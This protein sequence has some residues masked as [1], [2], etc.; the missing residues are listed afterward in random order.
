VK[1]KDDLDACVAVLEPEDVRA[2]F[3]AAF[4]RF[5]PSLD[6]MLPDPKALPYVGH[7]RW[8]GKIRQV[9]AAKYRD[10]KIDISD[11][12]AKVRKLIEESI[13]AACIQKSRP[14]NTRATRSATEVERL[15]NPPQSSVAPPQRA[16]NAFRGRCS[17][18]LVARRL[19]YLSPGV[20][21]VTL[22]TAFVVTVAT[23]ANEHASGPFVDRIGRMVLRAAVAWWEHGK[24]LNSISQC[25]PS[26]GNWQT[27]WSLALCSKKFAF[28]SGV[29]SS[30][31]TGGV[32][33]SSGFRRPGRGGRRG[34]GPWSGRWWGSFPS[35]ARVARRLP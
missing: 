27:L 14:A 30:W 26:F 6:M 22:I 31:I 18:R 5:S 23:L 11:Y 34:R 20:L 29:T 28:A 2:E 4:K 25:I 35:P 10:D 9:A 16:R 13:A 1:D 17:V 24:L 33:E 21:A 19:P 7:A 32:G 3:D 8:V 12:G 15:R